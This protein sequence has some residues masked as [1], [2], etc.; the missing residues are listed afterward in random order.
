[1]E[2]T[3]HQASHDS[4]STVAG[5]AKK[6]RKRYKKPFVYVNELTEALSLPP[7]EAE[8]NEQKALKKANLLRKF[9]LEHR[10]K[11][12][13]ER[14]K[15]NRAKVRFSKNRLTW[16]EDSIAFKLLAVE[17]ES[18]WVN[19][20]KVADL[21]KINAS[22]TVPR[23]CQILRKFSDECEKV[24]L[25]TSGGD[26]ADYAGPATFQGRQLG[27]EVNSASHLV[28]G[29]A[30]TALIYFCEKIVYNLNFTK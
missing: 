13:L 30:V 11:V 10:N 9:D 2:T 12:R 7:T 22:L 18:F 24:F 25:N 23:L 3:I 8:R 4:K 28:G 15:K 1:M 5:G 21:I 6:P 26:G 29:G 17:A 16:E 14:I 27:E 20:S 19:N